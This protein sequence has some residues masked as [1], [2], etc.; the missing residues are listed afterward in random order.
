MT[1]EPMVRPAWERHLQT[2]LTALIAAGIVWL[3]ASVMTLLTAFAR[4]EERLDAFEAN[5][6]KRTVAMEQLAQ[7]S[8]TKAE[9]DRDMTRVGESLQDHEQRI[10]RLEHRVPPR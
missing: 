8:A 7:N 6:D 3:A 10:R 5:D 1:R 9:H 4:F 2:I